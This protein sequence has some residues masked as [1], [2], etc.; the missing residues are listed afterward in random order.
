MHT[1]R[2]AEVEDVKFY[3]LSEVEKDGAMF[4]RIHGMLFHSAAVVERVDFQK[5]GEVMQVNALMALTEPGYSGLFDIL[6][7]ISNDINDISFGTASAS[8][9][10]RVK[11]SEC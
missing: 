4:F 9:W 5:L 2:I 8:V 3:S 6:V 10:R 11:V 1:F 7:P